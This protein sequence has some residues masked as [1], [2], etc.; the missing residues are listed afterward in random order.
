MR[1]YAVT[2]LT[3]GHPIEGTQFLAGTQAEAIDTATRWIND[4]GFTYMDRRN[5]LTFNGKQ[6]GGYR[7]LTKIPCFVYTH[8]LTDL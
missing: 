2:L 3:K 5:K 7:G 6:I 4:R 8:D 1:R